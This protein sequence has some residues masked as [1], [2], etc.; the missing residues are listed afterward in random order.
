[1]KEGLIV[2]QDTVKGK[3]I[4]YRYPR[5]SDLEQYIPMHK[6]FHA[7]QIMAS[8][9]ETDRP[10]ACRKLGAL[11]T[12]I[13]M[14]RTNALFV[15]ADDEL[16]GEGSAAKQSDFYAVVG[17][18]LRKK[19]RGLGIGKQL[20]LLLEDEARKLKRY[21]LYLTVWAANTP[22]Y[23]LYKKLGYVECGRLP[24]SCKT[25]AGEYTDLVHMI[26]EIQP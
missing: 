26:K 3:N 5:W 7:E 17:L 13:E 25:A 15:F 8:H 14:E 22:G 24:V 2:K 16:I 6:E 23:E 9:Q 11:L 20:M 4:V 10:T 21:K 12:E 18:V 1:M 19:A